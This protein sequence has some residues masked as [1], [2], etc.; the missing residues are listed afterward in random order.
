[1][2]ASRLPGR[3]PSGRGRFCLAPSV[4]DAPDQS[5]LPEQGTYESRAG[6][7]PEPLLDC[8]PADG[9]PARGHRPAAGL[10]GRMHRL[11]GAHHHPPEPDSPPAAGLHLRHDPRHED[12]HHHHLHDRAY[13]GKRP[14]GPEPRTEET[15]FRHPARREC[16]PAR[17]VREDSDHRQ[18]G[19]VAP[20]A[21]AGTGQPPRPVR[22]TDAEVP[23]TD[24]QGSNP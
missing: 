4:Q 17:P 5:R 1:M 8:H 15:V 6:H 24:R 14:A 11:S 10:C 16:P 19:A 18:A 7:H 21:G 20:E 22:R 2:P 12:A 13:T 23:G 9:R 3:S